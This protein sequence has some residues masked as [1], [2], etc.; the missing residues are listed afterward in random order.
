MIDRKTTRSFR[1]EGEDNI[2]VKTEEVI[3]G[4]GKK[5][6]YT[7]EEH[8]IT[9]DEIN[10][11]VDN[12][13]TKEIEKHDKAKVEKLKEIADVEAEIKDIVNDPK[14]IKFKDRLK[15]KK[16]ELMFRTL[17]KE[18]ALANAK[19]QIKEMKMQ[20]EDIVAWETQFKELKEAVEKAK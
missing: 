19:A 5:V 17:K 7:M 13:C 2:A 15:N 9:M 4:S 1:I 10:D 16:T 20:R 14:Y 18:N 12:L 3:N 8:D 11:V 6:V